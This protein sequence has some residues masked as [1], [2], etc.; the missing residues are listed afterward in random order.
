VTLLGAHG[1]NTLALQRI[2][3]LAYR[4]GPRIWLFLPSMKG[5]L[6]DPS[7]P[8]VAERLGLMK[9]W[10]ATKTRP[11]VCSGKAPPPFC[12]MI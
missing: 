3:A 5:A 4:G 9:Y 11:D 7:F 6:S 12:W 10:R 8:A 1:A 2:G